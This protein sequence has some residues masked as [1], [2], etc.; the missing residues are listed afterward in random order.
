MS[1]LLQV[2]SNRRKAFQVGSTSTE[3]PSQYEGLEGSSQRSS[4]PTPLQE[5]FEPCCAN[6][7]SLPV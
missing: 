5:P 2:E 6:G 7:K 4:K 3:F 1:S